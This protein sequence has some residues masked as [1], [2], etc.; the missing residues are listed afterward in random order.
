[1]AAIIDNLIRR[2]QALTALRGDCR[3]DAVVPACVHPQHRTAQLQQ[4][5]GQLGKQRGTVEVSSRAVNQAEAIDAEGG[6]L[7]AGRCLK[8]S[9]ELHTVPRRGP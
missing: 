5:L 3:A 6:R 2:A 9:I 8:G 1:M 7:R 4:P